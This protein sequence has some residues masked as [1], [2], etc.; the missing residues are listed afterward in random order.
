LD[1]T[2]KML[3]HPCSRHPRPDRR[4][5]WVVGKHQHSRSFRLLLL[6][7]IFFVSQRRGGRNHSHEQNIGQQTDPPEH[8]YWSEREHP[9]CSFFL[10]FFL[11]SVI[12]GFSLTSEVLL[13]SLRAQRLHSSDWEWQHQFR[14]FSI[15]F[16][17]LFSLTS[18]IL[19]LSLLFSRRGQHLYSSQW[20][21]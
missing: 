5:D 3:R 10:L 1:Q 2:G 12:F 14:C 9:F 7:S 20:E 19:R 4:Q 11:T 16:S 8:T 17:I 15:L 18:V 13:F 6:T 21:D